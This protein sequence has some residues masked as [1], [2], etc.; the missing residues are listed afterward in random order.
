LKIKKLIFFWKVVFFF[1]EFLTAPKGR[2]KWGRTGE[3]FRFGGFGG[4]SGEG[5]V[6]LKKLCMSKVLAMG[7][8]C[9][10]GLPDEAMERE[11][12]REEI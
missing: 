4:C 9:W 7:C 2:R 12:K 8:G 10:F 3:V 1:L 11:R 5:F 6:G